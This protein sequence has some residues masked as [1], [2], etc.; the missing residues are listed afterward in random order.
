VAAPEERIDQVVEDRAAEGGLAGKMK[1]ARE[2]RFADETGVAGVERAAHPRL[3]PEE[4]V[5]S[6]GALPREVRA[7]LGH[8]DPRDSPLDAV[9]AV[10]GQDEGH[11]ALEP[12]VLLGIGIEAPATKVQ[13]WVRPTWFK[14]AV[15]IWKSRS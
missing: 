14:K 11:K 7:H 6:Q 9:L 4:R 10:L 15:S 2:L 13:P 8:H 1:R 12:C 3:L 5:N